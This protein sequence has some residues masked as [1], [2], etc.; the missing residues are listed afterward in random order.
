GQDPLGG[1]NTLGVVDGLVDLVRRMCADGPVALIVDDMHWVDE[2]S[3]LVWNRLAR[4]VPQLPLLLVGACRPLPRT[5]T[6]TALRNTVV[7]Q[8]GA[9]V[10]I[11]RLP[12]V[13]VKNLI[14]TIVSAAPG[15]TLLSLADRA[16]GNPLYLRE[17]MDSLMRDR[18]VLVA[19]GT[20]EASAWTEVTAPTSLASALTHRLRF[21]PIGALAILRHAALLGTDF[22]LEDLSVIFAQPPGELLPSIEEAIVAGVLLADGDR[23]S[24]RHPLI[25]EALYDG[26][27]Q[28]VRAV[29]HRQAAQRLSDAGASIDTVARQLT[30]VPFTADSWAIG[31]VF[32]HGEKI[33][34]RAP[35]VG[36]ELFRRVVEACDPD[37]PRCEQLTA[38]L[39][40]VLYWLGESPEGEVR[41][42]LASTVDPD[43][44][45][46]MRWIL[47]CI[48]YRRGMDRQGVEA[49]REAANAPSVSAVWRARCRALLAGREALGLG[50]RDAAE[51]NAWRAIREA[52]KAGDLFAKGYAL[53]NLWLFRSIDRDH[54][55]G[56][57][58]VD[59]A[60]R[61]L[62]IASGDHDVD[63]TVAHLSL[64][65]LD[66]RVFSLQNLDRLG[67]ADETL[68][69]AEE[70]VRRHQLPGGLAASS[71]VNHYWSGRWDAAM[72]VLAASVDARGLDMAFRG[73]RE[74]GP[75]MLL[76]HGVAALIGALR[77]DSEVVSAHL[78]AADEIPMLTSADRESCDFLIIAEA[79]AAER[80]GRGEASLMALAPVIDE[81]YAPMMLRH[82]WLPDA[83][84]IGLQLGETATVKRALEMCET[85]A[86]REVY[87]ARAAAAAARCRAMVHNDPDATIAVARHY[88]QAGRQ[89]EMA[90]ALEDA[91]VQLARADR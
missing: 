28:A 45:G 72:A 74:S 67:Q 11:G 40:R 73:L 65:L 46:E 87:P 37:D 6:L 50:E 41:S 88:E 25:R 76:L 34:N 15:P 23:L 33:A 59:E 78:A 82:Q 66:N 91:A 56:L 44:A 61:S 63:S 60:L 80:E 58:L 57:R 14:T 9:L 53:E 35:D 32:Q 24:F 43:L 52:E 18:A 71:A 81:R 47:G 2:A 3:L 17:L 68:R 22:R 83:V 1:D 51:A 12:E 77:D 79:L 13:E 39:A 75:M 89:V 70:F 31:W 69:T 7:S 26:M 84:R 48:H 4:S 86:S 21:L 8:S 54:A 49:L 10:E 30:A 27:A 36:V 42:V 20:A 5:A 55:D 16:A 38:R 19:A 29:L 64:S 62:E 90:Q 85:E